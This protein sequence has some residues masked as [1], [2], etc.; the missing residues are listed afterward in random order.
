MDLFPGWPFPTGAP[1][2]GHRWRAVY[3]EDDDLFYRGLDMGGD[4]GTPRWTTGF[5]A[6]TRWQRVQG[7]RDPARARSETLQHYM[8]AVSAAMTRH[9]QGMVPS[10]SRR[11]V[12]SGRLAPRRSRRTRKAKGGVVRPDANG[13]L[14][15]H[16]I[17]NGYRE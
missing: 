10:G 4:N 8:H 14:F 5:P 12:D 15:N 9:G 16:R 7:R 1:H 2:Q 6:S 11:G 3:L 13:Q 17:S